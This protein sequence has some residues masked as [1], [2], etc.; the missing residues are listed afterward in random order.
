MI[1]NLKKLTQLI[2]IAYPKLISL[3]ETQFILKPAPNKWSKQEILG[4]LIDSAVNNHQ[5]FVRTQF[6]DVP[7]IPYDQDQWNR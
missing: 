6:Q 3:D 1:I 2:E 7:H 4:H 5:R